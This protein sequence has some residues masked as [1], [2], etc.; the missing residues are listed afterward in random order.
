LGVD[1]ATLA[2]EMDTSG[3]ERGERRGGAVLTRYEA[4]MDATIRKAVVLNRTLN[5]AFDIQSSGLDP[6][7]SRDIEEYARATALSAGAT[8]ELSSQQE[9]AKATASAE[10]QSIRDLADAYDEAS[11]EAAELELKINEVRSGAKDPIELK[12]EASRSFDFLNTALTSLRGAREVFKLDREVGVRRAEIASGKREIG[13]LDQAVDKVSDS[14]R[15]LGGESR[16]SLKHLTTGIAGANSGGLGETAKQLLNIQEAL[17]QPAGQDQIGE[18][19]KTITRELKAARRE[20]NQVRA[21]AVSQDRVLTDAERASALA[22][23][24]KI[25]RLR[26]EGKELRTF[27]REAEITAKTL[28]SSAKVEFAGVD[29]GGR[30]ARKTQKI[31]IEAETK[32]LDDAQAKVKQTRRIVEEAK[33][34]GARGTSRITEETVFDAVKTAEKGIK[35]AEQIGNAIRVASS[36][37]SIFEK[38]LAFTRPAKTLFENFGSALNALKEIGS[39]FSSAGSAAEASAAQTET[40]A[41]AF[42]NETQSANRAAEATTRATRARRATRTTVSLQGE[43]AFM[44]SAQELNRTLIE[45]QGPLRAYRD[46]LA[47]IRTVALQ[48]ANA[49]GKLN[50]SAGSRPIAPS[51]VAGIQSGRV[52]PSVGPP[53]SSVGLPTTKLPTPAVSQA[54]QETQKIK[55]VT[56]DAVR[57]TQVFGQ[58]AKEAY[59]QAAAEETNLLEKIRIANTAIVANSLAEQRAAEAQRR[60]A[61]IEQEDTK[62]RRQRQAEYQAAFANNQRIREASAREA[63]REAELNRQAAFAEE[64]RRT[65]VAR[66]ETD[67]RKEV[68]ATQDQVRQLTVLQRIKLAASRFIRDERGEAS[69]IEFML[70][71]EKAASGAAGKLSIA[72]EEGKRL[73]TLFHATTV[74]NAQNILQVGLRP[75]GGKGADLATE[76]L[77]YSFPPDDKRDQSV[78]LARS[79][80]AARKYADGVLQHLGQTVILKV[81]VP[82]SFVQKLHEAGN[83]LKDEFDPDAILFKTPSVPAQFISRLKKSV[84]DTTSQ[85]KEFVSDEGGSSSFIDAALKFG[86]GKSAAQPSLEEIERTLFRQRDEIASRRQE[87]GGGR[88][89]EDSL[90]ETTAE[91]VG[92]VS[93]V[94][95]KT[96]SL[97]EYVRKSNQQATTELQEQSTVIARLG[98]AHQEQQA[99]V[100]RIITLFHATPV[101]NALRIMKEGLRPG[102]G[103]GVTAAAATVGQEIP[104]SGGHDESIFF[105]RTEE[106]AKRFTEGFLRLLGDS[107]I[108]Q[109][110]FTEGQ[111]KKFQKEGA[112]FRDEFDPE[113]SL[114]IRTPHIPVSAIKNFGS[115]RNDEV[116]RKEKQEADRKFQEEIRER[117][118]PPSSAEEFAKLKQ[119]AVEVGAFI[120][121]SFSGLGGV[122]SKAATDVAGIAYEQVSKGAV[123]VVDTA[124]EAVKNNLGFLFSG[125]DT[126]KIKEETAKTSGLVSGISHVSAKVTKELEKQ[127]DV[128]EEIVGVQ[129]QQ[130]DGVF[131]VFD[132]IGSFTKSI[133]PDSIFGGQKEQPKAAKTS[134]ADATVSEAR[135]ATQEI[136]KELN[137]QKTATEEVAETQKKQVASTKSY[138]DQIVGFAKSFT[139]DQGGE[140]SAIDFF[141]GLQRAID[142]ASEKLKSLGGSSE[143]FFSRIRKGVS[144]FRSGRSTPDIANATTAELENAKTADLPG[145]AQTSLLSRIRQ[146]I[147]SFRQ[148]VKPAGPED[149]ITASL[150]RGA[151]EVESRF[152]RLSQNIGGFLKNF[153][154]KGAS[155]QLF[156]L[157]GTVAFV[158]ATVGALALAALIAAPAILGIGSAGIKANSQLEQTRLG[159]ASIIAA[160]GKL[161]TAG[162]VRLEGIDAL[163]AALPLAQKQISKLL[164]DTLQTALTFEQLSTGFLQAVGPGLAAGLSLDEIRKTV[165]SISQIIIPLT[166]NAAQLGQELRA[167]LSGDINQDT[168]VARALGITREQILAAKEAGTLA[169]FLNQKLAAAA[170][171]GQLMAQ[172]FEAATSNLKE[173]GAVIAGTVTEGLFRVLRDKINTV[174]PAIFE[175]AGGKVNIAPAFQGVAD[176]LRGVFDGIGQLAGNLITGLLGAVKGL[177]GV[178]AQ[179]R[180]EI[181]EIV[182]ASL[183]LIEIIGGIVATA[184]RLAA[185]FITSRSLLIFV[186]AALS[187][188]ASVLRI[189]EEKLKLIIGLVIAI[190]DAF[191]R[192]LSTPLKIVVQIALLAL[193]FRGLYQVVVELIP[194]LATVGKFLIG[195]NIASLRASIGLVTMENAMIAV[196]AAT[197]F[198]FTTPL[199]LALV[200][201]SAIVAA[202][203]FGAFGDSAA[204]AAEKANKI[205]FEDVKARAVD[206]GNTNQQIGLTEDLASVTR[207]N[208]EEQSRLNAVIEASSPAIQR[209]LSAMEDDKKRTEELIRLK[210]TERVERE[211][212]IR[213]EQA[214]L[215]ANLIAQQRKLEE[216]QRRLIEINKQAEGLE[217]AR[218]AGQTQ[219]EVV[220]PEGVVPLGNLAQAQEQLSSA[221]QAVTKAQQEAQKALNESL[222][223]FRL[224]QAVLGEGN[225]ASI[226]YAASTGRL[227]EELNLLGRSLG[228]AS[229]VRFT[230]PDLPPLAAQFEETRQLIEELDRLSVSQSINAEGRKI[231]ASALGT[232]EPATHAYIQALGTE[233]ERAAAVSRELQA[234]QKQKQASIITEQQATASSLINSQRQLEASRARRIALED[235]IRRVDQAN[236]VIPAQKGSTEETALIA[237]QKELGEAVRKAAEEENKANRERDAAIL[238]LRGYNITLSQNDQEYLKLAKS[239]NLSAEEQKLL[240]HAFESTAGAGRGLVPAIDSVSASLGGVQTEAEKAK[241]ALDALFTGD[242]TGLREGID[243]AVKEFVGRAVKEGKK[244]Q[245]AAKEFQATLNK[246]READKTGTNIFNKDQGPSL[247]ARIDLNRKFE[248]TDKAVREVIDPAKKSGGGRGRPVDAVRD[249]TRAVEKLK[250]EVKALEAGG[251]KLFELE[252]DKGQLEETKGQLTEILK[253]RRLL[254]QDER[255]PLPTTKDDRETVLRDLNR[256]KA[257]RESII[258]LADTQ[259]EAEAKLR[260]AQASAAAPVVQSELRANTAIAEAQRARREANEQ[261]IADTIVAQERLNEIEADYIKVRGEAVTIEKKSAIQAIVKTKE[262]QIAEE[263]RTQVLEDGELVRRRFAEEAKANRQ[264]E[265]ND[266]REQLA[267]EQ[268]RARASKNNGFTDPLKF[269]LQAERSLL[270]EN[271]DATE[272]IRRNEAIL[273]VGLISLDKSVELARSNQ[274][275][276]R[277]REERATAVELILINEELK[278]LLAGDEGA[279]NRARQ[280]A[281]TSRAQ[282]ELR[283]LQELIVLRDQAAAGFADERTTQDALRKAELQRYQERRSLVLEAISLEQQLAHAGEDSAERQRVAY[284]RAYLEIRQQSDRAAEE[285]IANQVRLQHSLDVDPRRLNDG[286]AKLLAS[287][288]TLQ[289]S[290]QDFRANGIQTVFDGIE[291]GVDKLTER[292]GAAG[293]AVNQL[294]KDLLKLAA[295]KLFEKLFGIQTQGPQFGFA[296]G[297]RGSGGNSPLNLIPGFGGG[298]AAGTGGGSARSGAGP[299]S[300]IVDLFRG[301]NGQSGSQSVLTGGFAGGNPAQ[302]ILNNSRGGVPVFGNAPIQADSPLGKIG[303]DKIFGGGQQSGGGGIARQLPTLLKNSKIGGLLSKIPVLGKFFGGGAGA[304][305]APIIQGDFGAGGAGLQSGAGALGGF[306]GLASGGLLAGGG[307]LGGLLGG[308]SQTGKLLGTLGGTLGAGFLGAAGVFGSGI[309]GALPALFSNPITAIAGVALLGAAFYFGQRAKRLLKS[310]HRLI[311][312]EYGIAVKSD[313]ILENVKLIGEGKFGKQFKDKQIETIRLPEV[314]EMLYEYAQRTGQKGNSK[315]YASAE[316]QDIDNPANQF[317]KRANGGLV[318]VSGLTPL[319]GF[320]NGQVPGADQRKDTVLTALR[321]GEFVTVPE[322]TQRQGI[323]RFTALNAGRASIVTATELGRIRQTITDL[324]RAPIPG[325]LKKKLINQLQIRADAGSSIGS[326]ITS[327][328]R[329][330][331]GGMVEGFNLGGY[332]RGNDGLRMERYTPSDIGGS[333]EPTQYKAPSGGS[334]RVESDKDDVIKDLQD[335]IV[336]L[337]KLVMGSN[338]RFVKAMDRLEGIPPGQVVRQGLASDPDAAADALGTAARRGTDSWREVKNHTRN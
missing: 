280:S 140:A 154:F 72:V 236:R 295:A 32:G 121:D 308:K 122:L 39:A 50:A 153:S 169:N 208:A 99:Q 115:V 63:Q 77:G 58:V 175:I 336:E 67:R 181:T 91:L 89:L 241:E 110:E 125:S 305:P 335:K 109:V 56:D 53:P 189:I 82:E 127:K 94:A 293:K 22:I 11:R 304:G 33:Q 324:Q 257:T 74:R 166:G 159:I 168:Q 5:D 78:F 136:T 13:F 179:N 252:L 151:D 10:A 113:G 111:L 197:S 278:K 165:I 290:L 81:Q 30:Q 246:Q 285:F 264:K 212:S 48:A 162:G 333:P 187:F 196:R 143:S 215:A 230:L 65:S 45:A 90:L 298:N 21:T 147:A 42:N 325:F 27:R 313:K 330:T 247:A 211:A 223:S 108:I 174:L 188:T 269:R 315:L 164:I 112:L 249:L 40:S 202:S 210:R 44:A 68:I 134:L 38:F 198:L 161:Q 83:I 256:E 221:T 178:F 131:A 145:N 133:I 260:I 15:E 170:A 2:L 55:A 129:K 194:L 70:G 102:A 186:S 284:L 47:E 149:S 296:G 282:D 311:A 303:L 158:T 97:A 329:Y 291:Q 204:E 244:A 62:L 139:S 157:A 142:G 224:N 7:V 334:I 49:V 331:R 259:K 312:G 35:F 250:Q 237:R 85:I 213:A 61:R 172:T 25:I 123:N 163:N 116:R 232:L 289:E 148:S 98:E 243:K 275:V 201:A 93:Q 231:L 26:E 209:K 19:L 171:T 203:A 195:I 46:L 141:L 318:S 272:T 206:L 182:T 114:R 297:N 337:Q 306:A 128:A 104:G 51:V 307:I 254:G 124:Y 167:I 207:L 217:E 54:V 261:A 267:I 287:Q 107:R 192:L 220:T 119:Q 3:L 160:V 36:N 190:V 299:L 100:E 233:K 120:V 96:R 191:D 185:A 219:R 37:A 248:E 323:S 146:R 79:E 130:S 265:I 302:A 137:K 16:T 60:R 328:S 251:G 258:K 176:G 69:A 73:V 86:K 152:A 288:K 59:S 103:K 317:I 12:I 242:P 66:A 294:L 126:Q 92:N 245:Q 274:R 101:A 18:R 271:T 173:A 75:R 309:A 266:A 23:G 327:F 57:S 268:E 71:L 326:S 279:T 6:R 80:E 255:A 118:R 205:K 193:T 214:T 283:T 273:A 229:K 234:L 281:E 8:E 314:R 316:I 238:K 286:V 262:L 135:K 34:A 4:R 226:K 320:R 76:E 31:V 20:L 105:T 321:G 319:P 106:E 225:A 24:E 276:Q 43:D 218:R 88:Q 155:A 28:A 117:F 52:N 301:R 9:V 239:T 87:Q 222:P 228:E 216:A 338:V 300:Q 184:L 235:E 64:Q 95:G 14:F 150:I 227:G 84:S 132:Q 29:V 177:S 180:Q 1:L 41:R 322:V 183:K 270:A 240:R 253:L 138:F 17:Q 310:I 156:E 200:A 263:A 277:L 332:V 144:S 199:G 292:F